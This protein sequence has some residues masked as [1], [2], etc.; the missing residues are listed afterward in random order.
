MQSLMQPLRTGVAAL[1]SEAV[2]LQ[3]VMVENASSPGWTDKTSRGKCG[4][5]Q[6]EK[7]MNHS[8]SQG[9]VTEIL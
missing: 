7:R 9:G 8:G 1:D 5:G 4:G 3:Q 6:G 2:G